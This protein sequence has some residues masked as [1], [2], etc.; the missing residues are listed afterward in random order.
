MTQTVDVAI[1]DGPR[2]GSSTALGRSD[3]T[4]RATE[5]LRHMIVRRQLP[6]GQQIRQVEVA[7]RLGL[8]R[9]PIREAL[10]SLVAEGLVTHAPRRGYFA[11]RMD[12][13]HLTQIYRMR[14]LLE[15][16][17]LRTARRPD[18]VDV[19][20][21]ADVNARIGRATCDHAVGDV[22]LANRAFHFGLF[23]LSPLDVVVR[24]LDRLW[25]MSEPYRAVYLW[26]GATRRR[27]VRE[28]D[29]MLNAAAEGDGD[30]LVAVADRHRAAARE[31]VTELLRANLA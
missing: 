14:E 9:S 11:A 10:S 28:H 26:L 12:G 5:A 27:I 24:E 3:L 19:D 15:T 23:A 4:R 6:P 8:S 20:R 7:E 18:P 29:Q 13:D 1:S 17:V 30:R 16:E 2:D 25:N 21:L 22:L 31:A